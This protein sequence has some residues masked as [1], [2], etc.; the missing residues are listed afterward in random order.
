MDQDGSG[1][2]DFDEFFTAMLAAAPADAELPEAPLVQEKASGLSSAI[3]AQHNAGKVEEKYAVSK[4]EIGSGSY[5]TVRKCQSKSTKAVR[6]IK[7]IRRKLMKD[8]KMLQNEVEV[9]KRMDHPNIVKLYE[10]FED[11][12]N[13]YLIMELCA[14]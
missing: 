6:A 14:S 12:R 1:D 11:K 10:T 8:A 9:M 5:G 4:N 2:I 13:F 3:F 7:T